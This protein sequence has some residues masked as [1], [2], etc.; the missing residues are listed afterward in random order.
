MGLGDFEETKGRVFPPKI[1]ETK[2]G[3]RKEKRPNQLGKGKKKRVFLGDN[4][5][6]AHLMAMRLKE[7]EKKKK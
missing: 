6:K 7:E 2:K 5:E 3:S 4:R 1:R